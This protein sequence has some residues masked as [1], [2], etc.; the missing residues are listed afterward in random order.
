MAT[1]NPGITIKP[2]FGGQLADRDLM[3]IPEGYARTVLNWF[4]RGGGFQVRPGFSQLGSSLGARACGVVQYDHHLGH[5]FTVIGTIDKWWT[6]DLTNLAWV[7][8][9]EAANGLTGSETTSQVFRVFYKTNKSYLI[10]V[11]GHV[12]AP[13]KWD[14]VT[15]TYS[16]M[17]GTPPKARCMAVNNNRLLLANTFTTQAN[18]HQV[19]VS[20]FND[21]ESGWGATQ[22]VNL[23]DSP[24]EI[25]EMR[26]L[27]NLET[28]IY[29][30]DSLYVAI[31]QG[32]LDPFAF[33]LRAPN[34]QGPISPRVVV[35]TPNSHVFMSRT[36]AL[37]QFDGVHVTPLPDLFRQHIVATADLG[38]LNRS[39][40]FYDGVNGEIWFIYRGKGSANPNL[41]L[42]INVSDM[43]A[44]PISFANFRPTAGIGGEM[45][46]NI[47][48]GDMVLPLS[49]YPSP[50]SDLSHV[51]F[52]NVLAGHTGIAVEEGGYTDN[53]DAIPIDLETGMRSPADIKSYFTANEVECLFAKTPGSQEIEVKLGSSVDGS[54]PTYTSLDSIN[55]GNNGPH[56]VGARTTSRL[57]SLRLTGN[58]TQPVKL[59]GAIVSGAARGLR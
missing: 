56:T 8:I 44:W 52:R 21:F 28:A 41:G 12:D 9:T 4:K 35:S 31:A 49:G 30:T 19:D 11:N 7:D 32:D 55:I 36:G 59:R 14:G 40:G 51:Y 57:F 2:P 54:N 20:A 50:I 39:F 1:S 43:T 37:W 5:R 38:A 33:E 18:I 17:G 27:G 23:M 16:N 26:E 13:K 45:E 15:A 53:G 3:D 47:R 22:T 42:V 48:I 6:W 29:K 34:I 46:E 10:G 24:G 25:V 58:A